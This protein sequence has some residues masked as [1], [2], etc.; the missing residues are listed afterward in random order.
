MIDQSGKD[1]EGQGKVGGITVFNFFLS[2]CLWGKGIDEGRSHTQPLKCP[3]N[4]GWRT[5]TQYQ[6]TVRL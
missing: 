6:L 4:Q 1:T 2:F 5:I 3:S